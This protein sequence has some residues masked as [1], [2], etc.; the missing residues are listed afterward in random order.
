MKTRNIII[1]TILAFTI[2]LTTGFFFVVDQTKQVIVLQFGEPKAV[3]QTPGL[4]FKLPFIQNVV[5]YDSRVLNLDPAQEEVIL[6]DQKRVV[7]DTI[8]RYVIKDPLKFFQTTRTE[9]ALIDR[10]GRIINSSVRGV[11]SQY[12]LND[13]LSETRNKIMAEILINVKEDEKNFGIEIVDLRLKRTELTNE[14]QSNVFD[15]MKTEREREA[16]LLRAEGQEISQK[17]KATADRQKIEIVAEAD[18]QSNIL[19]GT[20]EAARNKILNDAFA[21][22]P[23]FFEFIRSM[24]AYTDTFKDGSTTMVISPDSDFFEFFENSNGFNE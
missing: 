18:K 24:E 10:L 14:V 22:D 21:K 20:G 12:Y 11:I 19:R 7:V 3:Y 4:K 1:L 2:M 16:N 15:R 13:L 8:V 6:R 23:D 5:Y 9:L 17:I